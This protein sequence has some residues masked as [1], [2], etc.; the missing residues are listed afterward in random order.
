MFVTR[1]SRQA[2]RGVRSPARLLLALS[3]LLP[4]LIGLGGP[5]HAQ[6]ISGVP[7]PAGWLDD[8]DPS[9]TYA[10]DWTHY[11]GVLTS[12]AYDGTESWASTPGGSLKFVF[13]GDGFDLYGPK[14]P[15]LGI[16]N[17]SV[18]GQPLGSFDQY[19]P[20][21]RQA[22]QILVSSP[23]LAFG[24]HTVTVTVTGQKKPVSAGATIQL[25]AVHPWGV[26]LPDGWLDDA[27]TTALTYAGAWTH[28]TGPLT[29]D[30]YDGT[31]SWD[32]RAGDTVQFKV[33]GNGFD[34][35]GP[36]QP[37]LGIADVTVDGQPRAILDQY[38]PS[39]PR[40][41]RRLLWASP[42]L[43]YGSHV[44]TVTVSGRKDPGSTGTTVQLDAVQPWGVPLPSGWVDDADTTSL[45]Y[46]GAW[47]HYGGR[48]TSDAYDGTES[49][50]S[51]TGDTVQFKCNGDGF[52]LYGP[53]QPNLG[54]AEVNVDN[55]GLVGRFDQYS[56]STREAR[57]LLWA[58]PALS[59]GTHVVTVTV[60]GSKDPG[61]SGI[62]VQLDA[63]HCWAVSPAS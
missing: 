38:S 51:R 23:V 29:S 20:G 12:D 31:E 47:T 28:Y 2:F 44:V 35:Y 24:A 11:D 63:A 30:A 48:L 32:S 40:E 39:P 41:A 18:D 62:T 10:G 25:D 14:Q 22:R 36:L 33:T 53:V 45:T 8:S 59:V 26:P 27:N 58:S 7:L 34:L 6:Q 56:P 49:W 4:A 37:N 3:M 17:V 55:G 1:V 61:S 60:A 54:V 19:G 46:A 52:D 43:A 13:T 21:T 15:N 50:S 42:A 5:A 16:A 57:Q 9:I